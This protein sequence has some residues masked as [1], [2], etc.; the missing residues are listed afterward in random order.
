MPKIAAVIVTFNPEISIL[1]KSLVSLI[2]QV[3]A[4]I[5]VDNGS[6]TS[7]LEQIGKNLKIKTIF[8]KDNTG[9][10]YAL[11]QGISYANKIDPDWILTLDQDTIVYENAINS[12][13]D[14]YNKLDSKFKDKVG[15]I[16]LN[17]K[18]GN[19][20]SKF[21]VQ[22]F[23]IT[24]GNFIKKEV[25][26]KI[27]FRE[28]FFIDQVDFEFDLNVSKYGYKI[29]LYNPCLMTHVIGV[30]SKNGKLF[31]PVW[32]VYYITRNST[33]LVTRYNNFGFK[34]YF[35]QLLH[36]YF[37]TLSQLGIKS[38]FSLAHVFIKG[39]IDGIFGKLGKIYAP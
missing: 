1:K 2:S 31:E 12:S 20:E 23:V 18:E 16:C 5:I 35:L 14:A 34:N 30:A 27:S 15:L 3:D 10:A 37:R 4:I 21:T 17:H 33:F 25:F 8:L 22:K 29:L 39:V 28:D 24:S 9:I 36:T 19:P 6:K 38:S 26:R 7:W 11:N 32:R 13:F